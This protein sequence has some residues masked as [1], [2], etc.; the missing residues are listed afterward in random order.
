MI[1]LVFT[2]EFLIGVDHNMLHIK[3]IDHFINFF[4][5]NG[6]DFR[7]HICYNTKVHH[8]EVN[9]KQPKH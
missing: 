3:W 5:I 1:F 7:I 8:N 9:N 2:K 6:V 4:L